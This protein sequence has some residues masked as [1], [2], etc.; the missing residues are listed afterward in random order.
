MTKFERWLRNIRYYAVYGMLLSRRYRL[1]MLGDRSY[2]IQWTICPDGLNANSVIYSGGV[3]EDISFEQALVKR[4]NCN[5]I[6]LDPS[7]TG[8]KTMSKPENQIP[9]LRY[10]QT[11]LAARTGTMKM[12]PP[13]EGNISWYA[14]EGAPGTIEVPVTDVTSLMQKHGHTSIDLLKLDIEGCEYEVIDDVLK[15]KIPVKQLCADFDYGYVPGVK[16]RQAL[17]AIF[18]LVTN[19]YQLI[20]HWGGNHTFVRR[21]QV[22]TK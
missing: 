9:Q 14:K 21:G 3:G 17:G 13:V 5:I 15:R 10:S 8:V 1:E 12:A 6:L 16:R 11:A 20:H 19:G 4:F 2:G 22:P 18:K 7:P